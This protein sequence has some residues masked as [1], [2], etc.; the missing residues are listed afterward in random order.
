M[1]SYQFLMKLKLYCLKYIRLPTNL[2]HRVL[3]VNSSEIDKNKI[4][5]HAYIILFNVTILTHTTLNIKQEYLLQFLS[6]NIDSDVF[7]EFFMTSPCSTSILKQTPD[8]TYQEKNGNAEGALNCHFTLTWPNLL[9]PHTFF[10]WPT[11]WTF[12]GKCPRFCRDR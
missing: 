8:V 10:D 1:P 6:L 5:S 9:Y 2:L 4:L 11:I 12:L 3:W 7:W